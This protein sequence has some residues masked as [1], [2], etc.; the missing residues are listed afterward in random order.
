MRLI[1][2]GQF[3]LFNVRTTEPKQ[4]ELNWTETSQAQCVYSDVVVGYL[5]W[6]CSIE[7]VPLFFR[8][9]FTFASVAYNEIRRW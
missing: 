8:L 4:T 2:V 5:L 3:I 7:F 1:P 6:V 9:H